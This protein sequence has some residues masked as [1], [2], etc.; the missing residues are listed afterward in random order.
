LSPTNTLNREVYD[1]ASGEHTP[2]FA[3]GGHIAGSAIDH[4]V[5]SATAHSEFFATTDGYIGLGPVGT[6]VGERA[7]HSFSARGKTRWWWLGGSEIRASW[8]LLCAWNY[9]R[10]LGEEVRKCEGNYIFEVV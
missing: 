10:R 1:R 2:M 3:K 8:R 4:A 9:V 6:Q 5:R 7:R